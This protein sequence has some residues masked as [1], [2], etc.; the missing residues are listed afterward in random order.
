MIA[1]IHRWLTIDLTVIFLSA[2]LIDIALWI[3]V[4]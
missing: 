2:I 1:R 4:L 3:G